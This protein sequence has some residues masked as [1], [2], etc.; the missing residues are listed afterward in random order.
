MS[1]VFTVKGT[2]EQTSIALSF[3]G[4]GK[5]VSL[6]P[7]IKFELSVAKTKRKSFKAETKN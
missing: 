2:S 1:L 3:V 7:F 6:D 4:K 5:H